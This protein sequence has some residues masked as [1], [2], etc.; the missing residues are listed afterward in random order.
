MEADNHKLL[1]IFSKILCLATAFYLFSYVTAD[2]DLWGHLKFGADH[3]HTGYMANED[4]YSF[5]AHGHRWINHEWLAE[6]LFYLTYRFFGDPG[7]LFGKLAI[8]LS[9]VWI[10]LKMCDMRRH[11]PLSLAFGMI[12][13]IYAARMGFMIRPQLFSFLFFAAFLYLLHLY[14]FKDKNRLFFLPLLMAAWVNLHGGFIM[15]WA[16]IIGVTGWKTLE[17]IA[18]RKPVP[19]LGQLWVWL[20]VVSIA[21]LANPYGYRLL[22]FLCQTL[23]VPRAIT[24]W[25]PIEIWSLS[26][27]RFKV[28]AGLFL[29]LLAFNFRRVEGWEV[30]AI[31]AILFAAFRYQRHTP[32]FAMAAAPFVVHW[33]TE[34]AGDVKNRLHQARLGRTANITIAVAFL[35]LTGYQLYSGLYMYVAAQGRIIVNPAEYPVGAVRFLKGNNVKGNLLLPF[36]WGEYAIWHLY[37]LCRVSIDGRFRT[38]YPEAVIKDHFI[39]QDD[40]GGWKWLMETYPADIILS[41]QSRFFNDLIGKTREWVYV[42]SDRTAIVFLRRNEKNEAILKR[43]RE[44]RL[45][46]PKETVSIYFP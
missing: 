44:G 38:A 13:A 8:G 12:L 25:A 27:V 2:P 28:M 6:L 26:H 14:F 35:L 45:E 4:P 31:G 20:M 32:F 17:R 11:H 21:T 33:L 18:C 16:L 22:V 19:Q 1:N 34:T 5:T 46:R 24:E 9:V 36:N 29:A 30:A 23:S 15:G 3:W 37:P 43:F 10:L 39:H 7:L 40:T 42:Y 41:R